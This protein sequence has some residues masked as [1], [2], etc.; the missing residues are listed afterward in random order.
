MDPSRSAALGGA[1]L[2]LLIIDDEPRHA[3]VVAESLERVGYECVIATSSSQGAQLIETADPHVILTD[4]KMEGLSGLDL[5][6]KARQE[7]GDVEVIVITG[8]GDVQ[9]AVEAM[10]AGAAN[11]LEKPV[12]LTE[13]RAM[14]EKAAQRIRLTQTNQQLKEQLEEKFGFEGVVG[15]SGKMHEVIVKLKNIAPTAATGNGAAQA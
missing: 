14:V 15:S 8:H 13:L 7:R 10:K 4:L 5:L 6:R 11:F 9:T 1:G 12:N 2:K 3:E